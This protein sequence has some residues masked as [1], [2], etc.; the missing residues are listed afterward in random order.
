[1][2][3]VILGRF[4]PP[5]HGH[6]YLVDFARAM[7]DR[8]YVLVC[9]LSSEPIPGELRFRW[10]QELAPSSRVIHIT[11]EIPEARRDAAGATTI[12]ADTIRQ[13]IGK[14][15][16]RVF[17]SE[18][19][20]WDLA[21]RLDAQFIPVDTGRHNI[22]VSATEIRNDPFEHWEFIPTPVRPWF[23]RHVALVDQSDLARELADAL[24]TVVAHPYREF[25]QVT[26]NDYGGKRA[27]KPLSDGE[28]RRGA[29]ATTSALA[30]RANRVL[31][32]DLRSVK[33]LD[34]LVPET[35]P[36]VIVADLDRQ[37]EVARYFESDQAGR[38]G[39]HGASGPT[40]QAGRGAS[41]I[42]ISPRQASVTDLLAMTR[43]L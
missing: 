8:L 9:T 13:S 30:R 20:G 6:L 32:H 3:G 26:W 10:M 21:Y 28:I 17:A 22:P 36:A 1:M 35:A 16:G 38:A 4:M 39:R 33:D 12:W 34:D 23:V 15:I 42:V 19:Y 2:N 5:H 11:E 25:W 31:L 7:V 40:G 29:L 14:P 18:D 37:D 43:T 41:P 27:V 24:D